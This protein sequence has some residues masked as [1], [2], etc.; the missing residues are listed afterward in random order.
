MLVEIT[1]T[2][3]KSDEISDTPNNSFGP[4][5]FDIE[6]SFQDNPV[7]TRHIN[8]S[9]TKG[10]KFHEAPDLKALIS[11]E[12]EQSDS[13]AEYNNENIPVDLIDLFKDTEVKKLIDVEI[14]HSNSV[15]FSVV[16]EH[17][18]LLEIDWDKLLEPYKKEVVNLVHIRSVSN[19]ANKSSNSQPGHNTL[20]LLSYSHKDMGQTLYTI[21]EHFEIEAKELLTMFFKHEMRKD[22]KPNVLTIARYI[23][24]KS[25][26]LLSNQIYDILHISA[27][28]QP[29]KIGLEDPY[30]SGSIEWFGPEEILKYWKT[31]QRFSLVFLSICNGANMVDPLGSTAF[32]LVKNGFTKSIVAFRDGAGS[33]HSL[34]TFTS[35]FYDLLFLGKTVEESFFETAKSVYQKPG[36]NLSPIYY[37]AYD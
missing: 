1:K 24:K 20:L 17:S 30:D 3:T 22:P 14:K 5:D 10:L 19:V 4:S 18:Q 23:N 28:G 8:A 33:E 35:M 32:D 16:S 2:K 31:N 29:R 15:T 11:E 7:I 21:N 27:H 37:K 34:P 26:K 12:D 36:I 6:L 9:K 13:I 25:I